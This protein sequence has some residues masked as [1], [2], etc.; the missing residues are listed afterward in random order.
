MSDLSLWDILLL[1]DEIDVWQWVLYSIVI[2]AG[3]ILC[4]V[5]VIFLWEPVGDMI[6]RLKRKWRNRNAR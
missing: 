2:P 1:K 6:W 3:I 4:I 5:A